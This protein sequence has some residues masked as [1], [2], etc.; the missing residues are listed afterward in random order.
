MTSAS[1]HLDARHQVIELRDVIDIDDEPPIERELCLLLACSP[2]RAVIVDLHT[3]IV[4]TATLRLLLRLRQAADQY[5]IV[6]CVTARHPQAARIL[7]IVGMQDILRV[8][9]TL[10][11]AKAMAA[12]CVAAPQIP[13]CPRRRTPVPAVPWTRFKAHLHEIVRTGRR[14]PG[15]HRGQASEAT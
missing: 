10:A 4:T 2:A 1:Y 14:Q 5:G 3:P 6:L 12:A 13:A 15:D 7:H 8:T 11:G 9:A